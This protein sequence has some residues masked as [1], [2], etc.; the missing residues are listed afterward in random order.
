MDLRQSLDQF[1]A[2]T[3]VDRIEYFSLRHPR[4]VRTTQFFAD[5]MQEMCVARHD[6][7]VAGL[8]EHLDTGLRG[9]QLSTAHRIAAR[10]VSVRLE[11][12]S[13]DLRLCRLHAISR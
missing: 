3:A 12:I 1:A 10:T 2:I 11:R 6:G 5:V 9:G 13:K 4:L 8:L 7:C